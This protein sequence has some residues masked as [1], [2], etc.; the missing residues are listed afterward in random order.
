MSFYVL[1]K[2]ML[3]TTMISQTYSLT[4]TEDCSCGVD[5]LTLKFRNDSLLFSSI[6]DTPRCSSGE[7]SG[8]LVGIAVA[9]SGVYRGGEEY[10]TGS[11][12]ATRL[13]NHYR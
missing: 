6:P 3:S 8:V 1:S 4:E 12:M 13:V 11:V 10:S 9:V 7:S 5:E 2:L